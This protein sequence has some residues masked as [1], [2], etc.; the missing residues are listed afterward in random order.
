[1]DHAVQRGR[2]E[3]SIDGQRL[4]D[5]GL[6]GRDVQALEAPDDMIEDVRV[7]S[8]TR[9]AA[10][11]EAGSFQEVA[12]ART[13]VEVQGLTCRRYPSTI[14]SSGTAIRPG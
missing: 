3:R 9:P 6:D 13:N 1:V 5:V 11:R 12:S 4:A 14:G 7:R 10:L 8:M 2:V